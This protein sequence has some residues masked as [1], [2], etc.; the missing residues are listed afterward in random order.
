MEPCQKS[1]V[2]L[3]VEDTTGKTYAESVII[4][5]GPPNSPPSCDIISPEDGGAGPFGSVGFEA[6]TEDVDV[7][8][9][10]LTAVDV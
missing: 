3:Q 5:V 4:T 6:A 10:V 9:N 2:R 7:P 8:E 1:D